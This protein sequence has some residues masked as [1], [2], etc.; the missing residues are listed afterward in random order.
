MI[1]RSKDL[2]KS[3]SFANKVNI[4]EKVFHRDIENFLFK[5]NGIYNT[6]IQQDNSKI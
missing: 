4:Q 3:K 1:S 2:Y 6:Y 5:V